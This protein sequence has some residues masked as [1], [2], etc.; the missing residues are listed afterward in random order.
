MSKSNVE[1][2]EIGLW[3]CM[4]A[5]FLHLALLTGLIVWLLVIPGVLLWL[6]AFRFLAF[7]I[8]SW[9]LSADEF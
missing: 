3:L 1:W 7:W 9:L 4:F 6:L 5:L 2:I 8:M